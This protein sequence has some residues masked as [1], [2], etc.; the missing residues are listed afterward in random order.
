MGICWLQVQLQL[1]LHILHYGRG[2]VA[3]IAHLVRYANN[4][5]GSH[6]RGAWPVPWEPGPRCSG[7]MHASYAEKMAAFSLVAVRGCLVTCVLHALRF[8][9]HSNQAPEKR[10]FYPH[11][12]S[13]AQ[14]SILHPVS[15]ARQPI[16]TNLHLVSLAQAQP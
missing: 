2:P 12:M 3:T 15:K 1:K 6:L 13:Q 4:M 5:I 9:H 10:R 11:P 14:L 7:T 16:K 8:L